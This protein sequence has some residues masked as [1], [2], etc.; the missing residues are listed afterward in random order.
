MDQRLERYWDGLAS[1]QPVDPEAEQLD[2]TLAQ[3]VRHAHALDDAPPI[4][5]RFKRQLWEDL[6]HGATLIQ[7]LRV[8]SSEVVLN[9]RV[10]TPERRNTALPP[11][12]RR[13]GF[14]QLT[15]A[16]LVVLVLGL[17]YVALG[18]GQRDNGQSATAPAEILP[19]VA[20][21]P[22]EPVEE[23]LLSVAISA[24]E[25]PRSDRIFAGLA[26]VTIPAGLIS[27]WE[28]D[29][30]N[31]CPGL[32][33]DYVLAG[34]MTVQATGPM[35]VVPANREPRT[36]PAGTEVVLEAGDAVVLA[37][38]ITATFANPDASP[39]EVLD[40]I[41]TDD[42]GSYSV[43]GVPP[44]WQVHHVDNRERVDMPPGSATVRLRRVELP[45]LAELPVPPNSLQFAVTLPANDAGTPTSSSIGSGSDG[46]VRNVGREA[47]TAY[48]LTL[49]P[50][51]AVTRTCPIGCRP[52]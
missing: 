38:Q 12:P 50:A 51:D 5:T 41:V 1:G 25:L 45:G 49:E 46:E 13:W 44:E 32:R 14:A 47:V 37:Y 10:H 19:T 27:T 35:R 33:I 9:G 17:I 4:D 7:P 29:N 36:V 48:V 22:G 20:A 40:W 34:D 8:R 30:T 18:P 16:A 15:T 28:G 2:P 11:A 24:E 52:N 39:V 43:S 23:T 21:T 42:S 31:C 26:H 6:M 3:T